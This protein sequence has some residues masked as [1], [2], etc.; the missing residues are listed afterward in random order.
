MNIQLYNFLE[1]YNT[2]IVNLLYGKIPRTIPSY[3]RIPRAEL[4]E[5]LEHV[6]DGYIDLLVTGQTEAL[7]KVFRYMSRIHIAKNIQVSD[8]LSA[9]LMFPQVIRRLLA[10]EYADL[11]GDDAVRKFNQAL[12]Q[13]ETTAHRA[14]CS[15]VDI[16]QEHI[17]KRM[18]EHNDYLDEAQ[19]K[20]GID[21]SR[22]IIFK[23]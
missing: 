15:F 17:G 10:E 16:Y 23:A 19:K 20:F 5:M 13:T 22:F 3:S 9:I 1:D 21:L 14:A 12:E 8:V 7:D 18:K 2:Q 11:Q 6:L 4:K